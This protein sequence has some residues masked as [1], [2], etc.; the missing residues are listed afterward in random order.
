MRLS[1]VPFGRALRLGSSALRAFSLTG[2][3]PQAF[4]LKPSASRQGLRR[5]GPGGDRYY[6]CSG[7]PTQIASVLTWRAVSKVSS[8]SFAAPMLVVSAAPG[9]GANSSVRSW[10]G[11]APIGEAEKSLAGKKPVETP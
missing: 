9:P 6:I 10:F 1:V 3:Q 2:L 4:S 7:D 8:S 11:E 5:P